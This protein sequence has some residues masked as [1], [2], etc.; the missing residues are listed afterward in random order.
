[1][2][3]QQTFG[4]DPASRL[5]M[6]SDASGNSATYFYVAN[7]PLVDHITFAKSGGTRML[8]SKTYDYLNRLTSISS[9]PPAGGSSSISSG[10]QYN[11]ANQRTTLTSADSSYWVYQYD[12]LGQ[13][14]SG[15]KYWA[16]GT[17]VAGQQ[18]QYNFDDIGNR[19]TTGWGGDSAGQNLH[20]ETYSANNRNQYT[21]RSFPLNAEVSGYAGGGANVVGASDWTGPATA[22]RQG[23]YFMLDWDFSSMSSW[24]PVWTTLS[25]AGAIPG[26]PDIES[27]APNTHA[28][29][30]PSPEGF[31]YDADGNLT[32]DGRWQYT[33]D[34]ENRL[35]TVQSWY[36]PGTY[37]G[38]GLAPGMWKLDFTYD[39]QGRRIQKVMSAAQPYIGNGWQFYWSPVQTNRFLY[40]GWNLVAE[41]SGATA[42]SSTL[43]RS[44][45]WGSELSGSMQGAGGVGGLVEVSYYG[46]QT[47]NCFVAY[48]GNGNVC[49]LVN[50]ADGTVSALYDYGPFGEVIRATGPMAKANPFRFSTQYQDDESDLLIYAYRP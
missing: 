44:Y 37:A 35:V 20:Q 42:Q 12:S 47:T 50:A 49:G 23:N 30:K 24:L 17:P 27:I 10:Y 25:I 39:A 2:L 5:Y 16:N 31:T 6:V 28:Y 43:L 26:N 13:V 48:D 40:D 34:A 1:M 14:V 45:A 7:S 36:W 11:P 33:W 19:T 46:N 9:A 29:V 4:F 32:R 8:T 21:S 38:L 18:F 15:K 3:V 41:L 22:Y